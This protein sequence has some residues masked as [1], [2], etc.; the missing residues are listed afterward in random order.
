MKAIPVCP[1]GY[2]YL[3]RE[4]RVSESVNTKKPWGMERRKNMIEDYTPEE[5]ER[6]RIAEVASRLCPDYATE[7]HC[8][9]VVAMV[10]LK[11]RT[12]SEIH[13]CGCRICATT[14]AFKA[15]DGVVQ[16]IVLADSHATSWPEAFACALRSVHAHIEWVIQKEV[17][18]LWFK[19]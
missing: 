8:N 1:E 17:A 11:R 18:A 14:V 15:R 12:P 6:G 5:L 2:I 4:R 10:K 16:E 7:I 9:G 19:E 13:Y 3:G